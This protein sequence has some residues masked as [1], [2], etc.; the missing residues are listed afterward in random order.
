M[1]IVSNELIQQAVTA[2]DYRQARFFIRR[3]GKIYPNHETVPKWSEILSK[4][5][6]QLVQESE[7]LYQEKNFRQ[8]AI[9][10]KKAARIW[11]GLSGLSRSFNKICR[12][13]QVL[14]VG[15]VDQ[16]SEDLFPIMTDGNSR[17]LELTQSKLFEVDHVVDIPHY[18]TKYFEKWTPTDLGRQ[19]IFD[20]RPGRNYWEPQP[21]IYSSDLAQAL[22]NKLD[23]NHPDYN[24][25]LEYFVNSVSV[26]S[27][28]RL[29]VIFS[30]VPLKPEFLLRFP[31]PVEQLE[32]PNENLP[33]QLKAVEFELV[34]KNESESF[35]TPRLRRN[36]MK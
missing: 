8:A 4:Q 25:R 3:L 7:K 19:T 20:I 21:V 23:P 10:V 34:E 36:R 13:H 22:R 11:P 35:F 17:Y 5:S 32:T 28:Y 9:T 6:S 1:G 30:H 27:P 12:R 15:V 16:S 24:E 33:S 29:E 2:E 26:Q 18:R 31:F 14:K